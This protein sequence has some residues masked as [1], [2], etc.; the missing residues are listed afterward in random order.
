M[1]SKPPIPDSP[2]DRTDTRLLRALQ[3]DASASLDTLSERVSLSRNACWRRIKALEQ[4]GVIRKRVAVL[5]PESCGCGLT[6]LIAVRTHEHTADWLAR[7]REAVCAQPEIVSVW[8]TSG[9]TDYLL[10]AQVADMPAYDA[11]YQRLIQAVPLSDVSASF[12]M[13]AIKD[14]TELPLR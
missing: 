11:L 9:N 10:K 8:R 2:L 7:F 14:T 3:R 1:H 12:V 6:V 4:A 5:D 13:E